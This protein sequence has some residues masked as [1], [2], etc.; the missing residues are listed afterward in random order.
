MG[1]TLDRYDWDGSGDIDFRE[2][3]GL[4]RDPVWLLPCIAF[5]PCACQQDR[6]LHGNSGLGR[7]VHR[8]FRQCIKAIPFVRSKVNPL[9]AVQ[10]LNLKAISAK[11]CAWVASHLLGY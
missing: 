11:A 3:E 6:T 9:S 7:K 4:V 2:F 8:T 10:R 1:Q 5:S